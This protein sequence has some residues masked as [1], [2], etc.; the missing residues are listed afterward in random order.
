MFDAQNSKESDFLKKHFREY[1]L[2]HTISSVPELELR[3]FGYGVF[4]RK[5]AN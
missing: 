5:I 3:E 1:Y 4:K 2:N